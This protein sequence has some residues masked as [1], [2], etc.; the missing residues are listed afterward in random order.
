MACPR[1]D[2]GIEKPEAKQGAG[3]VEHLPELLRALLV[4]H[5][6]AAAAEQRGR[7]RLNDPAM[8]PEPLARLDPP[9]RPIRRA[10]SRARTAE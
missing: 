8:L 6:E 1:P 7:R 5:P 9:L 2:P 4:A 3:R 10:V